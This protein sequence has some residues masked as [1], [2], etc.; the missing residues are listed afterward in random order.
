MGS[1]EHKQIRV[2]RYGLLAPVEGGSLVR[3]QMKLAA[4][5]RNDLI[6]IE[7]ARRD[8]IRRAFSAHGDVGAA[9]AAVAAVEEEIRGHLTDMKNARVAARSRLDP[10]ASKARL[11]ELRAKAAVARAVLYTIRK[12]ART[13]PSTV[14]ALD[15]VEE[16][17]KSL[18]LSAR[19]YYGSNG[20]GLAWGTYQLVED[21]DQASR[22]SPLYDGSSP[23]DPRFVRFD[24]SGQVS[25]QLIGGIACSELDSDTQVRV[26]AAADRSGRDR[27]RVLALRVGSDKQRNPIWARFP[28]RL[29]RPLPPGARIKRVT[30]D[31]TYRGPKA[32]W[33]ALFTL[34]LSA[35]ARS[36]TCGERA[37]AVD[38]GWRR[39]TEGLRVA[40]VRSEDGRVDRSLDLSDHEMRGLRKASELRSV[41]DERLETMRPALVEALAV[42]T[43]PAWFQAATS[44]IGRWRSA[45]RFAAL[46]RRWKRE[47]FAGDDAAYSLLEGWRRRDHHL[48]EYESGQR[49]GSLRRR[50]DLY[51]VWAADLART[52][53]T[54]VIEEF[55]LRAVARTP[56][57]GRD[58][59]QAEAA[60]SQRHLASTSELRDCLVQAFCSRGGEVVRVEPAET[61][62]TCNVCGLV[63]VFDAAKQIDH[64]CANGHAWDQDVNACENLIERW[65]GGAG[66]GGARDR[67]ETS[68][69]EQKKESR[70]VRARRLAAERE[71]RKEGA[72]KAIDKTAE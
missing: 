29:H 48:W 39:L 53:R 7:R 70:Y 31:L 18:R 24:G 66:P 45:A 49:I 1:D 33:S 64:T 71:Q 17:A 19:S 11:K 30:V 37:V 60:R 27:F 57:A 46:A 23:N 51:R 15:V 13:N 20:L 65:R 42:V 63:E 50:K 62:M 10:P 41:R 54:L 59:Q 43:Q 56:P 6:A 26:E 28:M 40:Y 34:K 44:T 5:Y 32:E 16:R 58:T 14:E 52:F 22:R 4:L 67:E 35:G 25:V 12:T 3:E 38:L 55:D 69:L 8:A 68:D 36:E 61:T 9:E 2:Y 72:R 47:R 21:R